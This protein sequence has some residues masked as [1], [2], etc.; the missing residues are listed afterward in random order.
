MRKLHDDF[1]LRFYRNFLRIARFPIVPIA[2]VICMSVFLIAATFESHQLRNSFRQTTPRKTII[3]ITPTYR[4]NTRLADLTR[5]AN[6]IRQI[7]DLHWI[8]IED[9]ETRVTAVERMLNRTGLP[10]T[11]IPAKTKPGYPRRGWYQRDTALG[12]LRNY[13]DRIT[14]GSREAVVYFGDDDNAY[15]LRLFDEYIRK[16]KKIGVW[17]VGLVGGVLVESPAVKDNKVVGWNVN[18]FAKRKFA[19][20]MAGFAVHL[21]VI[22]NNTA[23]FGSSCK[24]GAGAPETCLLEDL[25][26]TRDDLEPFGF[27]SESRELYVWH[28]KTL[29]GKYDKSKMELHGFVVE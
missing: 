20:D 18:W 15:D 9:G 26:L 29:Q 19:T 14:R 1:R 13:T 6:T 17:G 10:F 23:V 4:R 12:Y 7:P 16:V 27:N 8:V 22:L 11:Y 5:M 28:T 2:I 24:R 25:G 21:N 3:I